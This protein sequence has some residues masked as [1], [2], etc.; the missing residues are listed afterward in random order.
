MASTWLAD[1]AHLWH[2]SYCSGANYY[3]KHI[4]YIWY[5]PKQLMFKFSKILKE[6]SPFLVWIVS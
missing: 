1:S 4:Y 3:L 5:L 6:F 2:F